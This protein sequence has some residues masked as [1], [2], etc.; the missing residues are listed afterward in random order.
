M[1]STLLETSPRRVKVYTLADEKWE[2]RGTGFCRGVMTPVGPKFVVLNEGDVDDV[3]LD[4][5]IEGM[6]QYQ[7]QQDTLIVWTS[8]SDIDYALSFQ[9][10]QGCQDLCDFLIQI[11][12][13]FEKGIS[14]VAIHQ[15][16]D[17][18]QSEIIAGPQFE[19]EKPNLDNLISL[20]DSLTLSQYKSTIILKLLD[21]GFQWLKDL[22]D[23]FHLCE[24][25]HLLDHL[26]RLSDIVKALVYYNEM[27]IFE[28]IIETNIIDGIVGI[29]EY[30]HEYP[31]S[32]M[33]LRHILGQEVKIHNVME[34]QSDE[35]REEARRCC[36][37]QFLRDVALARLLDDTGINC[38]STM[39][40]MKESHVIDYVKDDPNFL[41]DLFSLYENNND[42]ILD[43]VQKLRDG[44]S[45][46]HQF[47]KVV[48][49]GQIYQRIDFYKAVIDQGLNKMIEFSTSNDTDYIENRVLTSEIIMTIV[50]QDVSLFKTA[51]DRFKFDSILLNMLIDVLI[52]DKN[53]G[54]KTQAFEA[55]KIIINPSNLIEEHDSPRLNPDDSK[56]D[57]D[58]Y[59][60]FYDHIAKK[61]FSPLV[62]VDQVELFDKYHVICYSNICELLGFISTFHERLYSRSF[63]LENHLLDGVSKL[64][65]PR[66]GYLKLRLNALRCLKLIISIND[67][68]YTRYIIANDLLANFIQLLDECNEQ[69]NLV[70]SSCLNLLYDI[71]DNDDYINYK[72]LRGYL[73][74]T[75][76]DHLAKNYIGEKLVFIEENK[77]N[78]I[79]ELEADDDD[80][81]NDETDDIKTDFDL[82]PEPISS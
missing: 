71:V 12:R 19:L 48:K 39:I 33:N 62:N 6:T 13:D 76:R 49:N 30:D 5:Q 64:L 28:A 77:T 4:E 61:L 3:L 37:L 63:I 68:F 81:D 25:R 16:E 54:L 42:K 35:I 41:P 15:G 75:Y 24:E 58:F 20:S 69:N 29:L 55:L 70:N 7:R 80:E 47:V 72:L 10:P 26:H 59:L 56:M 1:S 11:Q 82:D 45:M 17:G 38:I 40:Q 74:T 36:V 57:E 46:L 32:K 60:G 67:E 65:H 23:V 8:V 34:I 22:I 31:Q 9:E 18:E 51:N 50:E 21:N 52:T 27:D 44:I 78:E 43:N 79:N 2:D 53:I 73:V 14:L 66:I